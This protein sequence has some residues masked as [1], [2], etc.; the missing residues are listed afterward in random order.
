MNRKAAFLCLVCVAILLAL[1]GGVWRLF[2][3]V[4]S[5]D[6]V[7]YRDGKYGRIA[8][9]R[10]TNDSSM[11]FSFFGYVYTGPFPSHGPASP[12]GAVRVRT[13]AGWVEDRIS[14]CYAVAQCYTIAPHSTMEVQ[15]A[16]IRRDPG[17]PFDFGI[18]FLRG[19]AAQVHSA[20]YRKGA[21]LLRSAR[22]ALKSSELEYTWSKG[23]TPGY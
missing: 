5:I 7:E 21:D 1:A 8:I 3:P 17:A 14:P 16:K 9:F 18:R 2:P 12:Y 19:T 23:P 6:F 20:P 22:Y 11:P 15:V 13:A 10:I 4:P